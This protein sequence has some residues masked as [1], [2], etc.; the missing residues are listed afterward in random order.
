MTVWSAPRGRPAEERLTDTPRRAFVS[1][2]V[3]FSHAHTTLFMRL[4]RTVTVLVGALALIVLVVVVGYVGLVKY[5][6]SNP[7]DLSGLE[8]RVVAQNQKQLTVLLPYTE[9]QKGRGLAGTPQ[10][11]EDTALLLRSTDGDTRISMLGMRFA[12]DIIWLDADCRVVHFV[13]GAKP[14]VLHR[15]VHSG[16]SEAVSVLEMAAGGAAIHGLNYTGATLNCPGLD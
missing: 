15:P 3:A 5:L 8:H 9:E 12:L 11:P 1:R 13:E 6:E 10:L 2:P 14:G 7:Q 16:P 4:R